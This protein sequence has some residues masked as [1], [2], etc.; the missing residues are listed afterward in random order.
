MNLKNRS[1][2][3]YSGLNLVKLDMKELS[4]LCTLKND[5][6]SKTLKTKHTSKKITQ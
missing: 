5:N 2:T 6:A 1:L 3:Y 4:Y